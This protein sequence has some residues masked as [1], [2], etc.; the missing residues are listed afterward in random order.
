MSDEKS[1]II[2]GCLLAGF[3]LVATSVLSLFPFRSSKTLGIS[4][5]CL[6]NSVYFGPVSAFSASNTCDQG[7]SILF[8]SPQTKIHGAWSKPEEQFLDIDGYVGPH[9]S[10]QFVVPTVTN[11]TPWRVIAKWQYENVPLVKPLWPRV[12]NSLPL[13]WRR[14]LKIKRPNPSEDT[15]GPVYESY[16][17]EMKNN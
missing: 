15:T 13:S 3:I 4:F 10:V 7:L 11:Q 8:Y 16:S 5:V 2:Y 1:K 9:Q 12:V 6:T 14:F 17:Q